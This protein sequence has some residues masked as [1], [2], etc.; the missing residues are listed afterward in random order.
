[1]GSYL[2]ER[3]QGWCEKLSD[4]LVVEAMKKAV[5]QGKQYWSYV[6]A[7]LMNWELNDVRDVKDAQ[8]KEFRKMYQKVVKEKTVGQ[9][10]KPVRT[11]KLPEWFTDGRSTEAE[12]QDDDFEVEK[13][14][15]VAELKEFT[16]GRTYLSM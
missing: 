12:F 3:I 2:E 13:A 10:R 16:E 1:M 6:D 5:E 15:L 14:K 9:R 8:E 11:E 4:S 7:I